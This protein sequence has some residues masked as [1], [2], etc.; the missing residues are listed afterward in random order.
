MMS[1]WTDAGIKLKLKLL[2]NK[3]LKVIVIRVGK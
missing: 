2:V 3:L 1:E